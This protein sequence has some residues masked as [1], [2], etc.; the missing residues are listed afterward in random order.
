MGPG[1]EMVAEA[2]RFNTLSILFEVIFVN[3]ERK[4]W[5]KGVQSWGTHKK[6]L[7]IFHFH[8]SHEREVIVELR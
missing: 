6:R 7:K 2:L 5:R 1:R 3:C 8:F 4:R